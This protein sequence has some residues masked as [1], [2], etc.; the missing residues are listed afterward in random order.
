MSIGDFE[1]HVENWSAFAPDF[2]ELEENTKYIEKESEF[3]L[4]DE[5]ASNAEE[6]SVQVCRFT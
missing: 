4:E 2:T 1:A 3:D 6:N 5:D